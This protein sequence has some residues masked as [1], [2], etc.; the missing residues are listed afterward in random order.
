MF[1]GVLLA[2]IFGQPTIPRCATLHARA[3]AAD[4][5]RVGTFRNAAWLGL[6]AYQVFVSPSDGMRCS[7]YPSCSRYTIEA[8]Q[9]RGPILGGFMGTARILARHSDPDLPLCRAAGRLYTYNP[10]RDD[11]WWRSPP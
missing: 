4:E 11:E 7:M 8:V 2:A 9:R 1:S 6:R 10:P 5:E 3:H